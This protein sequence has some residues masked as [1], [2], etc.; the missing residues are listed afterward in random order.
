LHSGSW[1][2]VA[3]GTWL[4]FSSNREPPDFSIFTIA[5]KVYAPS[6]LQRPRFSTCKVSCKDSLDKCFIIW[7]IPLSVR[8]M[9]S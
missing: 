9:L 1:K 4:K 8:S 6:R 3:M 7:T 2:R 5:S